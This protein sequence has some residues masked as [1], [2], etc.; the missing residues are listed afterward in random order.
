MSNAD[1]SA[2]TA[3]FV[4]VLVTGVVVAT[5]GVVKT[6]RVVV[7]TGVALCLPMHFADREKHTF[8]D[9]ELVV[10]HYLKRIISNAIIGGHAETHLERAAS[11]RGISSLSL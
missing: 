5:G 6:S 11:A 1:S 2:K 7:V 4:V 3:P 9:D 8:A 10:G